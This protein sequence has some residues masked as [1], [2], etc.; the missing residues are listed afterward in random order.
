MKKLFIIILLG[1]YGLSFA[2]Q[3]ALLGDNRPSKGTFT[4]PEVYIE[5]L[6]EL[7]SNTDID[8]IINTGDMISGYNKNSDMIKKE[9]DV[10]FSNTI[11]NYKK[12]YLMALGNHDIFHN[13]DSLKYYL[14]KTKLPRSYFSLDHKGVHFI[15]INTE[16]IGYEH[17]LS[18]EQMMWLES[19]L[20]LNKGKLIFVSGHEPIFPFSKHIGSSLDTN[21]TFQERFLELLKEYKV[22]YYLCGHEHILNISKHGK[23]TQVISGGAGAPLRLPE[24]YGGVNHYI[25]FNIKEKRKK[26]TILI[27][28]FPNHN[29]PFRAF[30]EEKIYI[31]YNFY[32]KVFP[33][34]LIAHFRNNNKQPYS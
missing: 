31:E 33:T 11:E 34:N 18:P 26:A 24:K 10:F 28:K 12:P 8:F 21:K 16:E 25:I 29:Y 1:F 13:N 20:R 19:D 22:K 2:F 3:F 9:W 32:G 4:P 30:V 6:K 7:Q 17:Q 5:M 23:L 14:Q 15:F 27:K